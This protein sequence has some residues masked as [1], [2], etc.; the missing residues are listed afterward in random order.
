MWKIRDSIV[1]WRDTPKKQS[2]AIPEVSTVGGECYTPP[3]Q[4]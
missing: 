1:K 4:G 2:G 3:H